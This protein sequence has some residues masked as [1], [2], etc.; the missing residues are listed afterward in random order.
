MS[1]AL[2]KTY[3]KY[4]T[5]R[6]MGGSGK[7]VEKDENGLPV[8]GDV[9]KRNVR[10]TPAMAATLNDGWDSI[11]KPISFY[12]KLDEEAEREQKERE[13]KEAQKVQAEKDQMKAKVMEE[14]K[15]E[16]RAEL[17]AEM[18]GEAKDVE[19]EKRKALFT[20]AKELG[21]DVAKNIKT[22]DLENKI[23]EFKQD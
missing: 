20:E 21:L 8:L 12:Y 11:E 17:K 22:E 16:L 18:Q 14:L 13:E 15:D 19:K 23:N 10:I 1:K 6:T 9:V 5:K 4:Y 3:T 2:V 7:S